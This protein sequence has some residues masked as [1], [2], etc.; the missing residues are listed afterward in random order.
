MIH[1]EETDEEFRT[2]VN[3]ETAKLPWQDLQRFFAAGKVVHVSNALDLVEVALH[4]AKDDAHQVQ[5][6]MSTGELSKVTD[7]QA[8]AWFEGDAVLWSVVVKP[9]VLVQ[10]PAKH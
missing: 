2:R 4:F 5:R 9:W 3:L 8:L 10:M 1:L 6:W 7:Q